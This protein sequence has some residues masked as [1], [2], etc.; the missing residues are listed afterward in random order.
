MK[1]YI[2]IFIALLMVA[3]CRSTKKVTQI[4]TSTSKQTEV[5][6]TSEKKE[7]VTDN[8]DKVVVRKTT[9]TKTKFYPPVKKHE[10]TKDNP[11]PEVKTTNEPIV[12][13][14]ETTVIEEKEVDKGVFVAEIEQKQKEDTKI[15]DESKVETKVTEKSK[16]P[17]AWGW[18][19][20][21]LALFAVAFIYLNKK[22]GIIGW[23]KSKFVKK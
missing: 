11:V 3:S 8:R 1:K 22:F 15:N 9:T 2:V 7:N 23:I 16:K 12:E 5:L 13:S 20:G 14:I 18:I 10:A 17:I 6:K 21:M 4:D 19:F